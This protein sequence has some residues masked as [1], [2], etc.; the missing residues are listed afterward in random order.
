M[1]DGRRRRYLALVDARV[2]ALGV[3]DPESPV[4]GVGRVHGLEPLVGGV[5]VAAD[6]QQV[7][8]PM[9]HP[10]DLQGHE[11]VDAT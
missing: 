5:G 6:G 8:V 11:Q 7:D 3:P 2:L 9:T 10:G 1:S 4:L